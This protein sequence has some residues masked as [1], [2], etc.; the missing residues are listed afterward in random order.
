MFH[1]IYKVATEKGINGM[2]AGAL[3][4]T[5]KEGSN[6]AIRFPLFLGL[7]RLFS[8]YF[9][10]NVARDLIT[11]G[12]TGILCVCLNQPLDVVKTNLQG[13]NA[14]KFNGTIDCARQIVKSDGFF[15]LYRGYRPRMARVAIEVSV[16]FA[17]Y[18][19]VRDMV[20]NY[21]EPAE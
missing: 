19:A 9:N 21:L 4:T 5:L 2:T 16:T 12:V 20:L 17:S 1:G 3:I 15:G 11:G 10:N 7:Q 13:L 14:E 8:P 6:H 18:N